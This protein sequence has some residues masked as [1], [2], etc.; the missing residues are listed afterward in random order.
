MKSV[1]KSLK[2]AVPMAKGEEPFDGFL[3]ADAMRII[4]EEA[5]S[6]N[7]ME[8]NYPYGMKQSV[9]DPFF[10]E[11]GFPYLYDTWIQK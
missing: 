5:A 3:A 6:V 9:Q 10:N 11:I 7:V 4:N 1:G 2:L 8:L